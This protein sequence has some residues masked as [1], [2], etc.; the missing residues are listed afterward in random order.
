MTRSPHLIRHAREQHELDRLRAITDDHQY[1][2]RKHAE[3]RKHCRDLENRLEIYATALN[4]LAL[5]NAALSGR[6]A[7]AAKVRALPRRR[8]PNP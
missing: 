3:L 7:D 8:P 1:L 2:K 5:E 6:D 4:Q